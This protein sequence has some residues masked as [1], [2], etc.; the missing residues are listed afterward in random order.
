MLY[1]TWLEIEKKFGEPEALEQITKKM[2]QK[3]KRR[4]EIKIQEGDIEEE[5]GRASFFVCLYKTG[6]F[7]HHIIV[8]LML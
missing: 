3:I 6:K 4:K 5:A 1:E 7:G 2:P 8:Q